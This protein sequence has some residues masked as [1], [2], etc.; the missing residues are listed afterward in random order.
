M[1][2]RESFW[3]K[4]RQDEEEGEII[5]LLCSV[6]LWLFHLPLHTFDSWM[7]V[8]AAPP[9]LPTIWSLYDGSAFYHMWFRSL[10]A[11]WRNHYKPPSQTDDP[12]AISLSTMNLTVL[13][14]IKAG[15]ISLCSKMTECKCMHN[16]VHPFILLWVNTHFQSIFEHIMLTGGRDVN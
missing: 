16:T 8:P 2:L 15:L 7:F 6:Y 14:L 11:H 3:E 1:I 5:F 13:P 12:I 4:K 10:P 9:S